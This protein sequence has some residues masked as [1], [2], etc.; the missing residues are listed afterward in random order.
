[1]VIFKVQFETL[2][3]EEK[4]MS[5]AEERAPLF[6]EIPGLLQKYYFK[7]EEPNQYGGIYIWD[8]MESMQAFRETELAAS[9]PVAYEVQGT[10]Q[11]EIYDALFQLR[12]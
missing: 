9:I 8:S 11:I 1:M 6:R 7:G 2:L 10:P 12:D 4:V 3:T 5:I